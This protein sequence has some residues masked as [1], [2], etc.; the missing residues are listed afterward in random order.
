MLMLVTGTLTGILGLVAASDLP[1]SRFLRWAIVIFA[2][3]I[4]LLAGASIPCQP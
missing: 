2:G 3:A 4:N 1:P